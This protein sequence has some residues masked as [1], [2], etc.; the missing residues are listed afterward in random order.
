MSPIGAAVAAA[1]I[2]SVTRGGT[3]SAPIVRVGVI[4]PGGIADAHLVPAITMTPG[5]V[6][7]SVLSRDRAR[8]AAFAAKHNAV[9]PAPAFDDLDAMLADPALD[10]VVI[11]SPDKL[12]A[13]QAIAAARAGKHVLVEKPMATTPEDAHAMV[14][15]AREARRVLGVAYHLRWHAGHRALID[16]I[17]AGVLGELLHVRVQW[18]Y[19][20]RDASNWRAH[21]EVGRWWSL[22][23]VGTHCVDLAR[24]ILRE[25]G[26]GDTDAVS[27]MITQPKWKTGHDETAVIALRFASGATAEI[28]TSVL[29]RAP[30]TVEIFG[31]NGFAACDETLGPH[32]GGTITID[33]ASLLFPQIDPYAGELADFGRAIRYHGQCEV[34]GEEGAR[35]VEI[36]AAACP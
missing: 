5:M 26:C 33:D 1:P 32:G 14:A 25:G 30:R 15:A 3:G 2:G 7:W 17:K 34:P 22:A 27:S 31:S 23:G 8:A 6:L 20:A 19:E 9:A 11:A 29:F 24:W 12:H 36:L 13:A 18:T 21:P 16:R 10:A 4:G 28:C 35:N